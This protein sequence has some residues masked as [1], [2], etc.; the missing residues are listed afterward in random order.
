MGNTVVAK[1]FLQ[2]HNVVLGKDPGGQQ[3]DGGISIQHRGNY[4]HRQP[5]SHTSVSDML[6]P[7]VANRQAHI[8]WSGFQATL[9][10]FPCDGVV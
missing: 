8:N 10:L 2:E 9:V 1:T 7:D 5:L 6:S 4:G 3:K